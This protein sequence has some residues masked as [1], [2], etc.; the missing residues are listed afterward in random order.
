VRELYRAPGKNFHLVNGFFDP[1]RKQMV[2]ENRSEKAI[3]AA[4]GNHGI[5]DLLWGDRIV[6]KRA[7]PVNIAY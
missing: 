2:I 1:D 3:L 4:D 5:T 6:F 7:S